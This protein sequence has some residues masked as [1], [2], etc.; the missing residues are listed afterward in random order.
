MGVYLSIFKFLY[1]NREKRGI[2][3]EVDFRG[4]FIGDQKGGRVM[5]GDWEEMG[6]EIEGKLRIFN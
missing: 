4:I 3:F 6:S 2:R 1:I 5:R